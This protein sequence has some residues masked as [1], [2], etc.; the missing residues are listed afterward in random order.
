MRRQI[1]A[2]VD[3]RITNLKILERLATSLNDSVVVKTFDS[4][5]TALDFAAK[6]E[7]DIVITDFKMPELDG[8]EFIRR[9]RALENCIDVPVM[10]ITAY[11]D[12]DLRYRALEAGATDYLLSPVDH[13]EFR[14]RSHNLLM[15]R[16]QQLLLK[17]RATSLEERMIEEER[18]HQDELRHSHELLLRVID[19]VPVRVSATDRNGRFVFANECFARAMGRPVQAIIGN[20]LVELQPGEETEAAMEL[21]RSLIAGETKPSAFEVDVTDP[22]GEQMVLLTNKAVLDDDGGRPMLVVTVSLDITDRKNGELA[23]LA[24]KEVAELANHSKTEF[25]ANMSHELRTPL[26]AIIGFSQLMADEVLGPLGNAKYTG[27]ARDIC[28]S[29]EHL[30]G[31]INDILDVSKLEAGKFELEEELID[32]TAITRNLLH[33]VADRASALEVAIDTEIEPGLPRL[34]ADARKLKQILLNLVTNALKFSQPGSRVTLRA[35]THNGTVVIEVIDRGIGMDETEITTAI[36]RFGQ[37]ASTWNRKH[38]GTGL[39]LPLAIGL[40]ELHNGK[41]DIRSRKGEGTTVTVTF[42]AERSV[43]QDAL[44]AAEQHAPDPAPAP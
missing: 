16:R 15:L 37:V 9:F 23:V 29:A 11:E 2:I 30:L 20:T 14:V 34:R 25:L 35:R 1:V 36:T 32:I 3:D 38:A 31:I 6:Q 17:E 18:R 24:A 5:L 19:A 44:R 40:V 21:D 4:P 43:P 41:L 12:K 39:G 33:F 42:P 27:Y 26:S 7:P 10:V 28:N 8:A 22:G 13:H